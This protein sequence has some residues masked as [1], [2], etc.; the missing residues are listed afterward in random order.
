MTDKEIK[1]LD[2]AFSDARSAT[3]N[4]KAAAQNQLNRIKK[5]PKDFAKGTPQGDAAYAELQ[6]LGKLASDAA[7]KEK[8][9]KRQFESAKAAKEEVKNADK[10]ELD[11]LAKGEEYVA[12]EDKK[13]QE[14]QLKPRSAT[15][16]S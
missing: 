7:T 10:N 2:K 4:A 9:A 11:A 12:P 3:R 14:A 6:R 16:I 13:E 1:L 15:A 5:F 8:E